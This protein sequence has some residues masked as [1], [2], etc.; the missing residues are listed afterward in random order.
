ML[1]WHGLTESCRLHD[2]SKSGRLALGMGWPGYRTQTSCSAMPQASFTSKVSAL[3]SFRR[4]CSNSFG[5][6]KLVQNICPTLV[7]TTRNTSTS[8][9]F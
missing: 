2:P 9:K 3:D 6:H 1:I 8:I 7:L 5:E 4:S